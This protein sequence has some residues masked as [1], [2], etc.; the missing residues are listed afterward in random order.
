MPEMNSPDPRFLDLAS[1]FLDGE[2]SAEELE[3]LDEITRNDPRAVETLGE[4]LNQHGT[5]AWMQRGQA[6]FKAASSKEALSA[7]TPVPARRQAWWIAIPLA[8]CLLVTAGVIRF[9]PAGILQAPKPKPPEVPAA[10]PDWR[11]LSFQDGRLPSADYQGT[12]DTRLIEESSEPRGSDPLLEVEGESGGRPA[13]LLWDL[14]AIPPGSRVISASV[15][16]TVTSVSGDRECEAYT[17]SRPWVESRAT[18]MEFASGRRWE[19]PGA[20]GEEDRG[21]Q[22]V[23][24]FKPVRGVTR[25]PLND[26]GV[27][28]VQRW[29]NSDGANHGLILQ[30]TDQVS[31]FTFHSRE[32]GTPSVRP[33]LTVNFLPAIR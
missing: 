10:K 21:S 3:A 24:R 28:I 25:I 17:A 29:I 20:K 8:A 27:A 19:A 33:K 32:A 4:L 15:E 13:L 14:R 12:R 22:A 26:A 7:S 23:A 1:R 5:L 16:L 31:E 30:M 11:T 6:S 9:A 2:A 18:W